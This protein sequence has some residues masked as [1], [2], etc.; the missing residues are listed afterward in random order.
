MYRDIDMSL[1]DIV[2]KKRS[3]RGDQKRGSSGK[4]RG[5][6]RKQYGDSKPSEYVKGDIE[7]KA[8]I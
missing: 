2:K 5:G 1:D 8:F 4:R 3:S 7:S 6:F